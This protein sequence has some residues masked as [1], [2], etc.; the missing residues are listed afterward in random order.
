MAEEGLEFVFCC[1][2]EED[3]LEVESS[4]PFCNRSL[5]MTLYLSMRTSGI[6]MSRTGF[7]PGNVS[8]DEDGSSLLVGTGGNE[9]GFLGN[10]GDI[11][12]DAERKSEVFGFGG[13]EFNVKAL[14][15]VSTAG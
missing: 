7:A 11:A 2:G 14:G 1:T 9:G 3:A 5:N 13:A 4:P 8:R 15:L 12:F 6:V 10:L